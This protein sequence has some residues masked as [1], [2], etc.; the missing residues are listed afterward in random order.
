MNTTEGLRNIGAALVMVLCLGV[1]PFI[2]HLKWPI[3]IGIL[4]IA[5]YINF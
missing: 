1:I 2:I 4:A 5:I 3:T